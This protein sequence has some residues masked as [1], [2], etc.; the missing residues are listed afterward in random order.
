MILIIIFYLFK[1]QNNL[2]TAFKIYQE[3]HDIKQQ[4]EKKKL[5]YNAQERLLYNHKRTLNEINDN[6]YISEINLCIRSI[7]N[8]ISYNPDDSM[9]SNLLISK[10]NYED[11]LIS[12]NKQ[13]LYI[14]NNIVYSEN[15]LKKIKSEIFAHI[16][17]IEDL[18]KMIPRINRW[19]NIENMSEYE[20]DIE[21]FRNNYYFELQ[22]SFINDSPPKLVRQ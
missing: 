16:Q 4:I 11:E 2:N 18:Y 5:E 9:N 13:L 22:L 20:L 12:L 1:M 19:G 8:Y 10:K 6:N 15:M 14:Q 17:Y 3:I 21:A 7:D